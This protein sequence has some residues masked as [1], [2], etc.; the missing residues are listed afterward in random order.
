[1]YLD[2]L[3]KLKN[4]LECC[5]SKCCENKKERYYTI[6]YE[7]DD[8]IIPPIVDENRQKTASTFTKYS[9]NKQSVKIYVNKSNFIYDFINIRVVPLDNNTCEII[10]YFPRMEFGNENKVVITKSY[11][12]ATKIMT[13][14]N[15]SKSNNIIEV[16]NN[17][18]NKQLDSVSTL[19]SE[20][21]ANISSAAYVTL[22][23][24]YNNTIKIPRVVKLVITQRSLE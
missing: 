14:V 13:K 11:I 17:Q 18:S 5:N 15:L 20:N 3:D 9:S 4:N 21:L 23:N 24:K 16:I 6:T 12:T 7:F 1:M 10:S 8:F 22:Q 2:C 19:N